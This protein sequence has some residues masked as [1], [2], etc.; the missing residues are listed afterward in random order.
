MT[1]SRRSVVLGMTVVLALPMALTWS[2]AV[3][4]S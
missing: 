2:L 1:A 3:M 4:T